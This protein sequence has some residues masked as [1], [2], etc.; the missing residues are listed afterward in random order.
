MSPGCIARR[1]CGRDRP[2]P[3]R[4]TSRRCRTPG[5]TGSSCPTCRAP[6]WSSRC[7][8]R[9]GREG[10]S[11]PAGASV[12]Q[13]TRIGRQETSGGRDFPGPGR[14]DSGAGT[15]FP[16][17]P[18]ARPHAPCPRR[19]ARRR[20]SLTGAGRR[21]PSLP[22]PGSRDAAARLGPEPFAGRQV[23]RLR[24]PLHRPRGQPRPHRH[25]GGGHRREGGAPAHVEPGERV[26]PALGA[27]R[28]VP[29]LPLGARRSA[30]GLA[31]AHG[32]GRGGEGDHPAARRDELPALAGRPAPGHLPERLSRL[33]GVRRGRGGMHDEAARGAGPGPVVGA[34]LHTGFRSGTGTSGWTA[35]ATTSSS[36]RSGAARWR[37]S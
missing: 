23:G 5:R 12:P 29:L 4:C 32:R 16:P 18:C 8:P 1:S 9:A 17:P 13:S 27:R 15:W 22:R 30:A 14:V 21:A 26:E 31:A 28:K 24:A 3:R 7:R 33:L 19:P 2:A 35:G 11:R 34:A 36:S 6:R 25:L 10:R 20:P 37:I